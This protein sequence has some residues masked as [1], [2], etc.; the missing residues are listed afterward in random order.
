[1][2]GSELLACCCVVIYWASVLPYL[3]PKWFCC[4]NFLLIH[5]NV[6]VLSCNCL[7][8]LFAALSLCDVFFLFAGVYAMYCCVH[9]WYWCGMQAVWT[10]TKWPPS[11][12]HTTRA[13]RDTITVKRKNISSGTHVRQKPKRITTP[14]SSRA[15]R[16]F[17]KAREQKHTKQQAMTTREHATRLRWQAKKKNKCQVNSHEQQHQSYGGRREQRPK[18]HLE[19]NKTQSGYKTNERL[20]DKTKSI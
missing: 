12:T 5:R 8:R 3:C 15:A 2:C 13:T 10:L 6:A 19:K 11:G 9:R 17:M 7:L 16:T 1:M 4:S 14:H 18:N 20:S